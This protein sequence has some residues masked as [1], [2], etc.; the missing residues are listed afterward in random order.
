MK[1]RISVGLSVAL[2]ATLAASGTASAAAFQNGSFE[3]PGSIAIGAY[4]T[5]GTG[6]TAIAGWTVGSGSIDWVGTYWTAADGARSVDLNG[7]QPG[8]IYQDLDTTTGHTYRVSFALSGNP[9][10]VRGLKT[11]VVLASDATSAT[12]SY[13]TSVWNNTL[14]DMKW[15]QRSFTFVAGAGST[16]LSFV[17]LAPAGAYGPAIDKVSVADVTQAPGE[18]AGAGQGGPGAQ[19]KNGGWKHSSG[20]TFRNQGQCVSYF[21]T[22]MRHGGAGPK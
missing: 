2:L 21:A 22:R 3:D 10:G 1:R 7:D 11:V 13:D 19:C 14:T 20:H 4:G 18:R 12:F 9:D 5:Y 6:S 8:S 17:S 16:R 15:Q